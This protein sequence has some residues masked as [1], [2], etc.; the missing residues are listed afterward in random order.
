MKIIEMK[1]RKQGSSHYEKHTFWEYCEFVLF[2]PF[3]FVGFI[4]AK[5]SL[6]FR[7]GKSIGE[8]F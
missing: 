7:V 3:V 2:L 4:Y 8:N 1:F 5:V 6:Y